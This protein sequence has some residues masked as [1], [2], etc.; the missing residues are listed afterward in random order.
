MISEPANRVSIPDLN[1]PVTILA[2]GFTVED[3]KSF[4]E[5]CRETGWGIVECADLGELASLLDTH[6]VRV[7][8]CGERFGNAGW[9]DVVELTVGRLNPPTVVV[10]ARHADETLRAEVL[11]LGAFDL[12]ESPLDRSETVRVVACAWLHA[13]VEPRVAVQANVGVLRATA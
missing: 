5:I 11:N 8:L 7:V 2:L 13:R 12:L 1:N 10:V 4:R 9:Q 6:N 3:R